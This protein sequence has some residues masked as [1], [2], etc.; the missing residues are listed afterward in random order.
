[1][2]EKAV[3]TARAQESGAGRAP[4]GLAQVTH[5]HAPIRS[6]ALAVLALAV[7]SVLSFPSLGGAGIPA[8]SIEHAAVLT[9]DGTDGYAF[10]AV[11]DTVTVSTNSGNRTANLR[12]V[13]WAS[14]AAVERDSTTCATWSAESSDRVQQGAA[15]RISDQPGR[16]V[17]A[18][19]VTKNV[20]P[21][22][23][24]VFNVHIWD[25]GTGRM[26]K[27]VS[28]DLA[29]VLA[30]AGDPPHP[31]ALPWRV[32]ARAVGRTLSFKA[33]A[34]ADAE[35]EW[36]DPGHGASVQLPTDAPTSG[37]S[38]WYAGHLGPGMTV[39]YSDLRTDAVAAAP[40][41]ALPTPT[42]TAAVLAR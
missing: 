2:A 41:V 17:R 15:L 25:S 11:R 5:V 23:S 1:M 40:V 35:P 7:V 21:Y 24:W 16:G 31:R 37:Y 10:D 33:W 27:L 19:T 36:G 12:T 14:D 22:G 18:I 32:C 42:D 34:T 26:D 39:E 28:I 13:F 38:G 6:T 30:I 4:R 29:P 9:P 20:F 3:P 8:P